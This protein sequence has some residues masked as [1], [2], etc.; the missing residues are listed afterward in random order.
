[1]WAC[2]IVAEPS[3]RS[4]KCSES[5]KSNVPSG[6]SIFNHMNLGSES[7]TDY[8]NLQASSQVWR[9]SRRVRVMGGSQV[10]E[11]DVVE[12]L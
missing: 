1:M 12:T 6:S 7:R 9:R 11:E 5:L 8:T 3:L 10:M 4:A 2:S